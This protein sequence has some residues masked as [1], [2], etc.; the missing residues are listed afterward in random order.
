MIPCQKQWKIKWGT[1]INIAVLSI[2]LSLRP[3]DNQLQ[4]GLF[5]TSPAQT[6][7]PRPFMEAGRAI[8]PE[9]VIQAAS[10]LQPINCKTKLN[11]CEVY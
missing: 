3:V 6:A 8:L 9:F 5:A 1:V 4:F 11:I 2:S 10:I 7:L